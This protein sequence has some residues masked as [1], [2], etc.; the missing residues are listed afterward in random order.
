MAGARD[1]SD[2][3]FLIWQVP[4][5]S[6]LE[7]PRKGRN[8]CTKGPRGY[9]ACLTAAWEVNARYGM[10]MQE[11][12]LNRSAELDLPPQLRLLPHEVDLLDFGSM[13]HEVTY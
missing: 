10:M 8:G 5:T 12:E 9:G 13:Q 7:P 6:Q 4:A 1:I 3:T 2:P 11:R